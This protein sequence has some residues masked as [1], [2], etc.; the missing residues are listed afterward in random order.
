MVN[1]PTTAADLIPQF[2][3]EHWPDTIPVSAFLI[4]DAI[5]EDGGH[6]LQVIH[7]ETSPP[8]LLIGMLRA[9]LVDLESRWINEEWLVGDDEDS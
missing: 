6:G 5:R 4:V 2:V 8:W 9:V 7:D 3:Q 1:Q